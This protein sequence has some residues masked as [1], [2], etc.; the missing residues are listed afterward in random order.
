MLM[1]IYIEFLQ[2]M[3]P[4]QTPE[5]NDLE[6]KANIAAVSLPNVSLIT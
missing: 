5:M 1:I 4:Y 6:L 2:K 3:A